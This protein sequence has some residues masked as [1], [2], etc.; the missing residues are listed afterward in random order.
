M[1]EGVDFHIDVRP[2]SITLRCPRI[3]TTRSRSPGAKSTNPTAGEMTGVGFIALF[4]KA[5]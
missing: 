5:K 4:A 2:V 3:A 1:F